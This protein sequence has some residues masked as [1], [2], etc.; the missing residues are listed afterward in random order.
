MISW[1]SICAA[2][3]FLIVLATLSI[4]I[5]AELNIIISDV[6][7]KTAIDS[8]NNHQ[9]RLL[10]SERITLSIVYN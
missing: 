7:L 1:K 2:K 8:M 10:I 9:R 5:K 6:Q 3:K 4:S